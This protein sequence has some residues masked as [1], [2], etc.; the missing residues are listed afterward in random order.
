MKLG[1][2][3]WLDGSVERRA[4]VALLPGEAPR[5]VDLNRVEAVRL[6]KLGEGRAEA[7]ADVLVPPSLRLVLEAG[8]RAQVRIRQT[9]AYA[10]KWEGRGGLPATL[11]PALDKVRLLPCLPRPSTVRRFDGT[12]LDRFMVGGPGASLHATPRPTLALI[13][14]H[15]GRPAGS[16]LALEDADG[17]VLGAWLTLGELPEGTLRLRHGKDTRE[18][19]MDLWHGLELPRLRAGEALLLPPPELRLPEG[20][21]PGARFEV[22]TSQETLGLRLGRQAPHPTVQ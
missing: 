6:A 2:A 16:C 3:L 14:A 5:V 17:V 8:P 15:G 20:L 11:A 4:L 13:G 10:R 9:L 21:L 1:T 19:A 22:A 7:L 12:L 18:T